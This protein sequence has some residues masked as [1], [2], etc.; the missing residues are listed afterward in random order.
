M[1]ERKQNLIADFTEALEA[2]DKTLE[3]VPEGGL[4][5]SEK[6]GEWTIRQVIHHVADDC[7]VYTFVIERALVIPDCKIY[8]VGFPGNEDWADKLDFADRPVGPA[9]DLIHAHRAFLAELVGHFAESWENEAGFYNE[10]GEKQAA[11]SIQEMIVMLTDH[12]REHIQMIEAII[13]VNTRDS[14]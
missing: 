7:N 4:D 13:A 3:K 2:F 1:N 10:A 9:L 5:W 12:M 11:S 14:A 8:F 6:E